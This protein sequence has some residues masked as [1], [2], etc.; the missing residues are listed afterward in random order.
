MRSEPAGRH[1]RRR[2]TDRHEPAPRDRDLAELI[3]AESRRIVVLDQVE[4]FGDTS[5]PKS[6][7]GQCP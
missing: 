5:A 3:V 1:P 4:R 2:A 7:G 6:G